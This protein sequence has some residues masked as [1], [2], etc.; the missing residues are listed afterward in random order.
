MIEGSEDRERHRGDAGF[1][2]GFGT[3]ENSGGMIGTV[4][5]RPGPF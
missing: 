3:G 5:G 2:V 4:L 1:D